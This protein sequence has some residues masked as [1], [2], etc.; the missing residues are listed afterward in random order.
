MRTILIVLPKDSLKDSLKDGYVIEVF[1]L[2]DKFGRKLTTKDALH[3]MEVEDEETKNDVKNFI[4]T[5]LKNRD[6]DNA[7]IIL[8]YDKEYSIEVNSNNNS[9]WYNLA[10][11]LLGFKK[12]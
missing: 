11:V 6:K 3:V 12:I 9:H 8:S 2:V 7:F 4:K 10:D 5:N 1:Q